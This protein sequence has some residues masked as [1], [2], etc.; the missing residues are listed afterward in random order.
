M[1]SESTEM[2]SSVFE[3]KLCMVAGKCK[4][5]LKTNDQPRDRVPALFQSF[6]YLGAWLFRPISECISEED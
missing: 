3:I 6:V 4:S 5:S 1:F 2:L